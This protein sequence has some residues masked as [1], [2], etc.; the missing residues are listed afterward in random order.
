LKKTISYLLLIYTIGYTFLGFL[1]YLDRINSLFFIS[2][3]YAA[4]LNIFNFAVL[5]LL[6]YI[7]ADKSN[8]SF[9]IFN[10]GGM[11][12]RLLFLLASVFIFLKFLK[13]DEYAF[14][15]TF[16]IFYFLQM[17]LEINYINQRSK[18]TGSK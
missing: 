9:L 12:V 3:F 1:F 15:F 7:S 13:I 8:K 4:I 2:S 16:F 11:G 6:F 18:N 5:L 17:T 14:I 10:L